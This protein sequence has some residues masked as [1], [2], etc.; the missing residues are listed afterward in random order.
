MAQKT[1]NI[2]AK[3]EGDQLFAT[4]FN[5]ILRAIGHNAQDFSARLKQLSATT[6]YGYLYFETHQNSDIQINIDDKLDDGASGICYSVNGGAPT[7][8]ALNT[9]GNMTNFQIPHMNGGLMKVFVWS[10]S[11]VSSG[12]VGHI[13]RLEIS[14]QSLTVVDVKGLPF[15]K[16]LLVQSNQIKELVLSDL[17]ELEVL[18]CNNNQISYLDLAYLSKLS[19]VQCN[20]NQ[21]TFLDISGCFFDLIVAS[22][23]INLSNIITKDYVGANK[24]S[25]PTTNFGFATDLRN[26][27]LSTDDVYHM[28]SQVVS[29]G[30]TASQW[31]LLADNP[32]DGGVELNDGETYTKEQV[33]SLATEKGFTLIF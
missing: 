22:N 20:D 28:L 6:T 17:S 1:L 2:P 26:C 16:E 18:S 33:E 13:E 27:S 9:N 25:T 4:E 32:C 14:N 23:N 12:R 30:S 5:G 8:V 24:Y 29:E 3:Q 7:Y 31:L 15:L 19:N 21:L 11:S 10:A